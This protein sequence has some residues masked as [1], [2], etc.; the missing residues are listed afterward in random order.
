MIG[1]ILKLAAYTY[2]PLLGLFAFGIPT[3]RQVRGS[4]VP[5]VCLAAPALCFAIDA[6]QQHLFG[7]Y[8]IGL[9]LLL[10]N[11]RAD[12]WRFVVGVLE[13]AAGISG[14]SAIV[15]AFKEIPCVMPQSTCEP[16]ASSVI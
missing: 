13:S 3:R 16:Y 7:S 12:V 9:E 11:G 8:Q 1:L 10:L 4:W 15:Y 6:N 5:W 14:S 2:G